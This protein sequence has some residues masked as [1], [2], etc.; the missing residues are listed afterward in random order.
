M[1]RCGENDATMSKP[2]LDGPDLEV[3]A[4]GDKLARGLPLAR[5]EQIRWAQ[6]LNAEQ[7]TQR[8][9]GVVRGSVNPA[10]PSAYDVGKAET[11][12]AMDYMRGRAD[13]MGQ[14]PAVVPSGT[15]A[16]AAAPASP[17]VQR[18]GG[19]SMERTRADGMAIGLDGKPFN[20]NGG[21]MEARAPKPVQDDAWM[22]SV[23]KQ[24]AANRTPAAV[25]G[26]WN[27]PKVQLTPEEIARGASVSFDPVPGAPKGYAWGKMPDGQY[28]VAGPDDFEGNNLKD[29]NKR[30]T[31]ANEADVMNY[32]ASL[33]QNAT[34]GKPAASSPTP[35]AAGRVAPPIGTD[36]DANLDPNAPIP[37]VHVSPQVNSVDGAIRSTAQ[38]F[39]TTQTLS[40]GP[41]PQIMPREPAAPERLPSA[42]SI[43]AAAVPGAPSPVIYSSGTPGAWPGMA[44]VAIPQP[45]PAPAPAPAAAP[46]TVAPP[47]LQ[48]YPVDAAPA[49]WQM[50]KPAP[51]PAASP[52]APAAPLPP[53]AATP[54]APTFPNAIWNTPA[55]PLYT[56]PKK[57]KVFQSAADRYNPFSERP[58]RGAQGLAVIPE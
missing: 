2:I 18:E 54:T 34:S 32:F 39:A 47:V 35:P 14:A 8:Q 19:S 31:F 38:Q 3:Q 50:P 55:R 44:P 45:A 5:N 23:R 57:A 20:P 21:P 12:Q 37:T 17:Y 9:G 58:R 7:E 51:A 56:Q 46:V 16:P 4:I 11:T 10:Q 42:E 41:I 28:W 24:M 13:A 49:P 36:L 33:N 52:S 22:A 53:E 15:A 43:A 48:R 27:P 6:R 29:P 40:G 26:Q 30:R 25:P 1:A